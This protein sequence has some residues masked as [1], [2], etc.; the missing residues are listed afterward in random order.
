MCIATFTD[1]LKGFKTG[2]GSRVYISAHCCTE[3]GRYFKEESGI[4]NG[5]EEFFLF[6]QFSSL[7]HSNPRTRKSTPKKFTCILDP[8]GLIP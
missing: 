2:Y 3:L 8:R 6:E 5:M 4:I 1:I 7:Y